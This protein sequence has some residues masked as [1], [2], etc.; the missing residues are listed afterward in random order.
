MKRTERTA[1]SSIQAHPLDLAVTVYSYLE[2]PNPGIL[3]LYEKH[4]ASRSGTPRILDI[5]CGCG[6]TI[7]ELKKRTP[8]A[9]ATGIEPNARAAELASEACEE[10]FNGTLEEWLEDA[11]RD[12][13]DVVVLSEVIEHI[14]DPVTFLRALASAAPLRDAQWIISV[15]NYAVWHNRLRTL[16]GVQSY[17][18]SGVWDRTH[19]RFFT[20]ST[21][22]ELLEYCGFELLDATST[23]SIVQSATPLLRKAFEGRADEGE[24]LALFDSPAYALYQKLVEPMEQLVCNTWPELLGFQIAHLARVRT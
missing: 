24:H 12:P 5:G 21:I 9:H 11:P 16:F 15:P 22:R 17:K 20:R 2:R 23:P 18:W 10:V 6:T 14:A 4:V 7:R 13:I 3:S 8:G 1:R 19:L